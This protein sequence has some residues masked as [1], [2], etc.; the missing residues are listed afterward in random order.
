MD[1][2]IYY[3]T[4]EVIKCSHANRIIDILNASKV[5]QQCDKT[6]TEE[7]HGERE[8]E[9]ERE[10]E[11]QRER[12]HYTDKHPLGMRVGYCYVLKIIISYIER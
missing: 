8:R 5:F 11:G 7:G 10:R 3:L 12:E 6:I 2:N 9:R 1:T 4:E